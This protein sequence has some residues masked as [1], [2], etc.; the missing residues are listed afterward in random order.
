MLLAVKRRGF[1]TGKV[2]TGLA[3]SNGCSL[4]PYFTTS[5]AGWLPIETGISFGSWQVECFAARSSRIRDF[6]FLKVANFI[7]NRNRNNW[8]GHFEVMGPCSTGCSSALKIQ[9]VS[10]TQL[11]KTVN[12]SRWRYSEFSK[13]KSTVVF[14][15]NLLLLFGLY[16]YWKYSTKLLSQFGSDTRHEL[17][18]NHSCLQT[19]IYY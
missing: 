5:S 15:S 16:L 7:K 12:N 8:F 18:D 14:I 19:S 4:P 3:E 6:W 11:R 1:V 13:C 2:N 9:R 10:L 17:L